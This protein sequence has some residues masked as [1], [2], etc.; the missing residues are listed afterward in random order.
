MVYLFRTFLVFPLKAQTVFAIHPFTLIFIQCIYICSTSSIT[1]HSS[2]GSVY[3]PRTLAHGMGETG[4]EL[5]ALWLV[6]DPLHPLCHSRPRM[7]GLSLC[8]ASS[9]C[10][11]HL[12]TSNLTYFHHSF[13]RHKHKRSIVIELHLILFWGEAFFVWVKWM[14]TLQLLLFVVEWAATWNVWIAGKGLP[15]HAAVDVMPSLT[16]GGGLRDEGRSCEHWHSGT[17][18]CANWLIN[19][20]FICEQETIGSDVLGRYGAAH[21]AAV[22]EFSPMMAASLMLGSGPRGWS[23]TPAIAGA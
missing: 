5:M 1:H 10:P 16:E 3:C 4:I 23:S 18:S 2:W 15:F 22:T 8:F 13:N 9:N 17:E 21:G 11:D 7:T 19:S 14:S 20:C 12:S 6:A